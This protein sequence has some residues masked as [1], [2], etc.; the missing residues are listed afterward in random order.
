VVGITQNQA[1]DFSKWRSDRVME[2]S[3]IKMG[4]IDTDTLRNPE[5]VFTIERYF[6]GEY[7]GVQPV[8][9]FMCYPKYSLP[10]SD[11]YYRAIAYS[12]SLSKNGLSKVSLSRKRHIKYDY[13]DIN[14]AY[15]FDED[16]ICRE[17]VK[18]VFARS[19]PSKK[20]NLY[21]LIGNVVEWS[22]ESDISLGYSC[23]KRK[24]EMNEFGVTYDPNS[25]S[26]PYTGFR[27]VCQWKKGEGKY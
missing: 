7:K 15:K 1:A 9:R 3:L 25:K 11:Q 10:S 26:N 2:F 21:H 22:S 17:V 12:D 13:G 14:D 8:S 16:S 5:S 4:V 23:S 6:K 27:N 24:E 18:S 20:G 19:Y